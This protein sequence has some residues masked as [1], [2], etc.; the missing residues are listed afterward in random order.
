MYFKSPLPPRYPVTRLYGETG[1]HFH[2]HI[3][4]VTGLWIQGQV[5]AG[6]RKTSPC[7]CLNPEP[8]GQHRGID[9]GCL[10]GIPIAAMADG[11]V[12]RTGTG[13]QRTPHT[14]GLVLVQ[15][16]SVIDYD[17]WWLT[18]RNIR[19]FCVTPG[20]RIKAGDRI[21]YLGF[22]GAGAPYLHVELQDVE[23]QYHPP[24]VEPSICEDC[25]RYEP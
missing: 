6:C 2:S 7:G 15:L 16:V 14:P 3:D 25:D 9:Y 13:R 18:Y 4:D 22:P 17:S 12:V 19:E 21:G 1:P 24:P 10:D 23:L 5:C 11:M 20:D 8:T